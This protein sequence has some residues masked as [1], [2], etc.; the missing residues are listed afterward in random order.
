MLLIL[1]LF[2]SSLGVQAQDSQD[3]QWFQYYLQKDFKNHFNWKADGGYR[4]RSFFNETSQ[5]L[6]RTSIGIQL[7][8]KL[9]WS[10]GF[11]HLGNFSSSTIDRYEWRPHIEFNFTQEKRRLEVNHR[12]RAEF[13]YFREV[14]SKG[15]VDP[16]LSNRLRPRY[17]LM[18]TIT[19]KNT[20]WSLNV[21]NELH[22]HVDYQAKT[23]DFN[24]NRIL[25]GPEFDF[26]EN[27]SVSFTMNFQQ[28]ARIEGFHRN[29]FIFWFAFRHKL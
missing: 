11:A 4:F 8:P 9:E 17:R 18:A 3:F 23:V 2:S 1:G 6:T 21:G 26:K 20:D 19:G 28:T 10:A 22:L 24:Q 13:R 12:I 29:D 27:C 7:S 25:I 14:K 5:Y 15:E 16:I